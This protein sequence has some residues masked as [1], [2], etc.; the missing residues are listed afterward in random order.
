MKAKYLVV[1]G[2][3]SIPEWGSFVLSHDDAA[4]P[5]ALRAYAQALEMQGREPELVRDV[6]E[7][8]E[9][10]EARPPRATAPEREPGAE[11]PAIVR[12]MRGEGGSLAK[13]KLSDVGLKK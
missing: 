1:R 4:T 9:A 6:L 10:L 12:M 13:L 8:V 3:G 11:V 7:L 2:D 5:L